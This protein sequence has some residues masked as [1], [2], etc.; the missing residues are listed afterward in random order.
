M[1]RRHAHPNHR[2]GLARRLVT[3]AVGSALA[4]AG[5]QALSQGKVSLMHG[6]AEPTDKTPSCQMFPSTA[7]FNQRIDDLQRFPRH[8]KSDQWVARVGRLRPFHAD[9]G[10]YDNPRDH[11]RYY[12]IPI[13]AIDGSALTTRWHAVSFDI[14][15]PRGDSGQGNG[16]PSE[17]D[18][19]VPDAKQPNG[20]RIVRGCFPVAR[21]DRRFPIP[22]DSSRRMEHGDCNDAKQCGDRHLLVVETGACR[23]WES[24]FTYYVGGEW[25]VWSTAAWDLNSNDRRPDGWTSGDAAGLPI[26]PL[27]ARPDEA[28]S[29]DIRHA[30]RVTFRDGALE[31][32][33]VWPASHQAGAADPGQIPFGSLLRLS[34]NFVIPAHWTPQ[35]KTLA[36]AMKQYGLYVA[37][38]GTDLYVQ[39]EPSNKWEVSTIEQI[40]SLKME[41]FEFVDMHKVTTDR[42]FK[43][44]SY[45][46]VW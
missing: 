40:Q 27:L 22:M 12:G 35:A 14:V 2:P 34:P 32:K 45:Q 9:F 44:D 13:N 36:K 24:Y 19:A 26:S 10:V 39:G 30:L 28:S 15:D 21:K 11:T 20:M 25:Q 17:S 4:L 37:D 38:I 3:L 5:T 31:G 43:E 1:S 46:G 23:L 33:Y 41:Q 42:R 29:G 18:C 16:V 7:I 6:I 8:P